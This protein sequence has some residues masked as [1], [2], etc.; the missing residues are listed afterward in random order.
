MIK[1]NGVIITNRK[2]RRDYFIIDTIE[3]G[4]GLK[5]SEVK[6]LRDRRGNLN[7][8]FA[9]IVNDEAFLYNLHISSYPFS[10][11]ELL[12]PL[13]TRKLLLHKH[14]IQRLL[15]HLSVGRHTLIPLKLYFKKGKVKVELALAKGKREY[16]KRETIRRKEQELEVKRAI[17]RR[18]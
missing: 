5:G 18:R 12:D 8:S 10:K 3:A 15:G 2:A 7:E 13:R 6:S 17:G 1:G 14:Q 16:D 4:I 9:R 11:I